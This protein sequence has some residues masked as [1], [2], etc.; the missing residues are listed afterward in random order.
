VTARRHQPEFEA[1]LREHQRIVFKV[2]A[3]Y[4]SGAEDRDDLA[5]EICTQLW[6]SF[7]DFD[8]ARG[9]FSTWMYRIALNVAIS[10]VRRNASLRSHAHESLQT[11]HLETIAS[12]SIDDPDPRLQA[13]N[14]LIK[15]LDSLNRALILL[16]LEDRSY[17]EI[18]DIL[19][20]SQTNVA[21]KINRIKQKLRGQ[22]GAAQSSG[23]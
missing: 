22:M 21:T 18:A 10:Q 13:L 11:H 2:A 15:Q 19:G 1:R 9:K 17:S 8:E 14:A 6:R 16:Y 20:I 4:A 23:A 12:E 5:Q 3:M 7:A